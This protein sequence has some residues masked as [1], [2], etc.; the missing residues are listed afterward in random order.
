MSPHDIAIQENYDV[1]QRCT[2]INFYVIDYLRAEDV[3]DEE[4][5]H[6]LKT[7]RNPLKQRNLLYQWLKN[8]SSN[9]YES[10]LQVMKDTEQ[11][12]VANLLKGSTEG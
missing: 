4:Q 9:K 8:V 2:T 1:L 3:L 6:D 10:F 12:H 11:E 7:E 5:E